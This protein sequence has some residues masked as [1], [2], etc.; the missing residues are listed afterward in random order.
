V[1]T[2]GVVDLLPMAQFA[3]K[4]FHLQGAAGLISEKEMK[5]VTD[6]L[7]EYNGLTF[8]TKSEIII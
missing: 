1:Q 2:H 7:D 4:S 8:D 6:P 3:I 5:S